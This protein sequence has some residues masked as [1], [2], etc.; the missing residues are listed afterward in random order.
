M[1]AFLAVELEVARTFTNLALNSAPPDIR[2][3]Y[4]QNARKAYDAI[5]QFS[6]KVPL[7]QLEK[8]KLAGEVAVLES[9]IGL[10]RDLD[11]TANPARPL[12]EESRPGDLSLDTLVQQVQRF[13]QRCAESRAESVEMLT[14]NQILMQRTTIRNLSQ[15][16]N[17]FVISK[18]G[19]ERHPRQGASG[20]SLPTTGSSPD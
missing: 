7:N 6:F 13:Q 14:Q 15:P 3:R 4:L 18:A 16:Q 10:T 19:P 1:V 9:L 8:T 11:Q 12:S 17:L 20:H 5:L 2:A